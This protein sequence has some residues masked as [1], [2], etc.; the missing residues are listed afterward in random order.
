M[1]QVE[2][3][4]RK[5]LAAAALD[6]EHKAFIVHITA[7]SVD[8][9]N[10]VHLFRRAQIAHLKADEA[11]TQVLSKYADFVDVF[12]PKLAAKL[13]KHGISNHIIKFVDD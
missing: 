9:G 13:P 6:L 1:K 11:L 8:L 7:L 10:E 3:R 12:S 4:G 5:E 2:L